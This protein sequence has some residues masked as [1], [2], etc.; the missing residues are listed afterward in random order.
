[1]ELAPDRQQYDLQ[2]AAAE[3]FTEVPYERASQVFE[4]LTG[5][6]MSNCSMHQV[7]QEIGQVADVVRILPSRQK[8]EEIIERFGNGRVWRACSSGGSRWDRSASESGSR[9]ALGRSAAKVNG[10]RPKVFAFI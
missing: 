7:A 9:L 2:R 8:V 4:R 5:I 6:K 3:L 1:L 10:K